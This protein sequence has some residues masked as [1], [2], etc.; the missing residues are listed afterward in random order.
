MWVSVC[1]HC[2]FRLFKVLT[3]VCWDRCQSQDGGLQGDHG[4]SR[5]KRGVELQEAAEPSRDAAE[6]LINLMDKLAL[7][8]PSRPLWT[9]WGQKTQSPEIS[10]ETTVTRTPRTH[11]KPHS[12]TKRETERRRDT[13]RHEQTGHVAERHVSHQRPSSRPSPRQA[14]SL[15]TKTPTETPTERAEPHPDWPRVCFC[16]HG[17]DHYFTLTPYDK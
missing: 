16:F 8:L 17:D 11:D 2:A 3:S 14:S 12:E 4:G 15:N 13:E 7:F 10:H 9:P 5:G 6:L 1:C